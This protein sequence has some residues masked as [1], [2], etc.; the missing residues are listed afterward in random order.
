[1]RVR[2]V[3]VD[4]KTNPR[5]EMPFLDH[6][7][8]LRWRIIWSALVVAIAAIVG[9]VLVVRLDV[10]GILIA[11]VRP[12][13]QQE[14]LG[15]LSPADPF[16]VTLKLALVVGLILA[17]PVVVYHAWTF[18]SPALERH[19]RRAIV[20]SLYLGLVL[21][22][23]GVA[24]GYFVALPVTLRF[25][26]SFQAQTLEPMIVI[27]PYLGFVTK[28]L[29]AF[30]AVFEL[31]V[32]VLVLSSLGLVTPQFLASKRRHALVGLTIL[33]SVIT[34]GDVIT[35]TIVMMLPLML[36]YE[37]SILLSRMVYRRRRRRED[38]EAGEA[39]PA[40]PVGAV[41]ATG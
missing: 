13:V 32:V 24:M 4:R 29:L 11:P 20:P 2:S 1:M 15:Y 19:E 5:A 27:G 26:M 31:P 25:L 38:E 41:E 28:L 21:F 7:E 22:A 16:W 8:E 40:A 39:P 9:F 14:E 34:P 30:G 37:L 10:L 17:F 12:F 33:A 23:A 18:F 36:L 3:R 35:L 6:L